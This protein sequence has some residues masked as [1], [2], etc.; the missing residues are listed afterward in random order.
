[1]KYI[2][3]IIGLIAWLII[4]LLCGFFIIPIVVLMIIDEYWQIPIKL[5]KVF[6]S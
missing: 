3:S 1:M 6:E 5:L 4:T 2:A